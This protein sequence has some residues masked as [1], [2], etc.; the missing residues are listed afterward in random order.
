[1]IEARLPESGPAA[2]PRRNGELAFDA[3]WQGRAFGLAAALCEA[4]R[5]EWPEFQRRLI[6]ALAEHQAARAEGEPYRYWSC[7]LRALESL[8]AHQGWVP[9]ASVAERE[10]A[11][12]GRPPGHDHS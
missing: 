9:P 8:V 3:P 4:G 1:V 6:V 5:F 12:A 10:R 2:P 11:L 7:W